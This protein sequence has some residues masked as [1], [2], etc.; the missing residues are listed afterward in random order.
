VR[1]L[2]ILRHAKSSWADS[3][4]DDW[5]RPLNKRGLHDAPR[6]GD[7]LRARSLVPDV[8]ITSDAVRAR[9][10]AETVAKSAG[11]SRELVLEPMLYLATPDDMMTVLNA[12][13]DEA[14]SVMI[15]GHNPGLE[16]LIQQLTG[17]FHAMPT[18]A[19]VQLALPI[20]RWQDLDLSGGATVVEAWQPKE[21]PD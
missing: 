10:T 5:Q 13:P 19:L 7:R 20:D 8:I 18:A 3:S 21:M 4:L 1:Q 12:V 2:L 11:Y 9:T 15:V 14:R 16:G 6:V 17:E